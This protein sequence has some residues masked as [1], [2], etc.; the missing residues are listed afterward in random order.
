MHPITIS[1]I[2]VM[3]TGPSLG[4]GCGIAGSGSEVTS[5]KSLVSESGIFVVNSVDVVSSATASIP[6]ARAG[7]TELVSSRGEKH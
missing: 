1:V 7:V 6:P 3:L 2:S 5:G 4:G